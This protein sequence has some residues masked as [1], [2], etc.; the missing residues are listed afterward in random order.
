MRGINRIVALGGV[1]A[2]IALPAFAATVEEVIAKHV[3]ARGGEQWNDIESMKITGAYMA[4]SESKTFTLH[5]KRDR[6][7]H[8][9]MGFLD[10][11]MVMGYD[12]QTAWRDTGDGPEKLDGL[13][14]AILER[15]VDFATPFFDYEDRG[16]QVKLAGG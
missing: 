15:E 13:D 9:D 12:G 1:V 16:Y 3:E 8:I 5:R 10:S 4:F 7:Y 11:N 6:Q 14:R 2:A